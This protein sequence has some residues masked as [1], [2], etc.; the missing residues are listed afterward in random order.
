MRRLDRSE[1]LAR[2]TTATLMAVCVVNCKLLYRVESQVDCLLQQFSSDI[3]TVAMWI[4][5]S[6]ASRNVCNLDVLVEF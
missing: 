6:I 4:T 5:N 2:S 1:F 3:V